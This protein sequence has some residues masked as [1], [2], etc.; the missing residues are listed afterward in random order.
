MKIMFRGLESMDG[1]NRRP[2]PSSPRV[3]RHTSRLSLTRSFLYSTRVIRARVHAAP[4]GAPLL[5]R[6]QSGS[7]P[8]PPASRSRIFYKQPLPST[9]GAPSLYREI[10]SWLSTIAIH[11]QLS[12][13][14]PVTIRARHTYAPAGLCPGHHAGTHSPIS[15]R[16]TPPF[17]TI[18]LARV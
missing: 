4:A 11:R 12:R 14:A 17:T 7:P 3:S 16:T 6:A 13:A 8:G 1:K 2:S 15:S 10:P 9:T 18:R 5:F